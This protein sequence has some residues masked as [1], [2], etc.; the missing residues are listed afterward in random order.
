MKTKFKIK[1]I[2]PATVVRVFEVE[3]TNR[4]EA[5]A[6]YLKGESYEVEEATTT[7]YDNDVEFEIRE[8]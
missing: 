2:I 8:M 5:Y 6:E 7:T 4:E 1:A 3:A